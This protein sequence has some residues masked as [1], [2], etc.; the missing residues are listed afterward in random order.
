VARQ[1]NARQSEKTLAASEN[2]NDHDPAIG[3]R[4]PSRSPPP[5]LPRLT[6]HSIAEWF[7]PRI[8]HRDDTG[9]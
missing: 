9:N 4:I 8:V 6:R 7:T 5:V 2:R 1:S 3:R